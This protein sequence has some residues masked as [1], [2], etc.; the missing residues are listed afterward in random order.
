MVAAFQKPLFATERGLFSDEVE[1]PGLGGTAKLAHILA[2]THRASALIEGR[3]IT[4][5]PK[6]HYLRNTA[7]VVDYSYG[8]LQKMMDGKYN[9]DDLTIGKAKSLAGYLGIGA[10]QLLWGLLNPQTTVM[11]LMKTTEFVAQLESPAYSQRA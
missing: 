3:T 7:E 11:D 6:S 10:I 1:R 2:I 9:V 4:G 8:T 5:Y